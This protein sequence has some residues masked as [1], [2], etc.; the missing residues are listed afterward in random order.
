[1]PLVMTFQIISVDK[2]SISTYQTCIKHSYAY[3]SGFVLEKVYQSDI[4]L[5][6]EH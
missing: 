4:I 2:H 5:I 6:I 1:M 3:N